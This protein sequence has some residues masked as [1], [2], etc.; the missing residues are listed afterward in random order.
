[1][2][3]PSQKIMQHSQYQIYQIQLIIGGRD[4]PD[5]VEASEK[6]RIERLEADL[7]NNANKKGQIRV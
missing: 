7:A 6:E 3:V 5:I 1:M 2:V 4:I